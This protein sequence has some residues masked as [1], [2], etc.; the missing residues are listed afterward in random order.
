VSDDGLE[1]HVGDPFQE[2]TS[3]ATPCCRTAAGERIRFNPTILPPYVRR[4]KSLEALIPI[5]YLKGVST[6]CFE[7]ALAALVGKDAPGL[8]A[9]T[10]APLKEG[11]TD[12]HEHWQKRDLSMR[13]YVYF[14]A[15]GGEAASGKMLKP[16][17][18]HPVR[19]QHSAPAITLGGRM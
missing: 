16:L 3:S 7:E 5:L 8:S 1:L 11:W 14:W 9:S 18:P 4:T 17:P 2:R 13:R 10:I 12:E 6:G 15:D 19:H